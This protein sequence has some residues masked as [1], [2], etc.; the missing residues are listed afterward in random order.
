MELRATELWLGI[1]SGF[2]PGEPAVLE[3]G[4]S[5]EETVVVA[6]VALGRGGLAL[7]L[8]APCRRDHAAGTV[9]LQMPAISQT[10]RPLSAR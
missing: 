1:A 6:D 7:R 5:C 2:A 3:P 4:G 10:R 8:A 9:V